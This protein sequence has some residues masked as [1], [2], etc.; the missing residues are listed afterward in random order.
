MTASIIG[1]SGYTGG[2]LLRILLQHPEVEV[3]EVTSERNA[4]VPVTKLHP[5]LR[6]FTELAFVRA[7]E[8]KTDCDVVFLATPHGASMDMVK[9]FMETGMRIVDLSADFRLHNSEDY[10]I[11]YGY[12]HKH[13]ELLQRAVYGL[14][15]L[16]REQIKNAKLV[17]C[18]GCLATSAILAL[19]PLVA[20]KLIDAQ[21]IVVDAK[22]G[23]SASGHS[24]DASTH[25]PD[26]A[27]VVRAYKPTGHRHTAEM[28][29][30]LSALADSRVR[31]SFSPHAVELVR[32]IMT[33][34]HAFLADEN[35]KVEDIEIWKT[36]RAFYKGSPFVRFVK[37][38]TGVYRY[39][40]PKLVAGTNFCDIGF[41]ID[42]HSPRIVAMSAIDNLVKG[43][44]GQATQC[45][46][47][48]FGLNEKTGLWRPGL[49]PV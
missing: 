2:D 47:L 29:Q 22:I 23:S 43:A 1:A 36:Y 8:I 48:M 37:E 40:E 31:I 9:N 11:W 20:A 19:A 46:N 14:P 35:R 3:R 41:E 42:S 6:G 34:A 28:E 17:A 5:N 18:P 38:K 24:F 7:G 26:R 32:G 39:P 49:H 4:G 45:L 30:E 16:H 10:K 15:E 27:G 13:P 25:H 33:T 44:G 21:R 12:A